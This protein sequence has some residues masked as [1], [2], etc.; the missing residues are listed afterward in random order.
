[1]RLISL[2]YLWLFLTQMFSAVEIER[3]DFEYELWPSGQRRGVEVQVERMIPHARMA[4]LQRAGHNSQRAEMTV[5]VR[6]S[7]SGQLA[8]DRIGMLERQAVQRS[9]RSFVSSCP[10]FTSG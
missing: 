2:C 6:L 1:M 8:L 3:S 7:R 10:L 9:P 5:W 4:V